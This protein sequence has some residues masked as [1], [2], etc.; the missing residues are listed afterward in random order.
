MNVLANSVLLQSLGYAIIHSLWQMALLWTAY[1]VITTTI[2]L[3]S[4]TKYIL[5][6]TIQIAGFLW[7][8][9]TCSFY[10]VQYINENEQANFPFSAAR[11]V[12]VVSYEANNFRSLLLNIMLQAEQLLPYLSVAYLLVLTML[13]IQWNKHYTTAQTLKNTGLHKINVQWKLFVKE[14]SAL[15]GIKKEVKI[16]LSEKVTTPLTIGFLKPIILVPLASINHLSVTQMEAVLLHELAHIKRMDYLLHL[17]LSVIE[18]VLFFNPFTKAINTHIQRERENSCDDW[19][20]QFQYNPTV[21][22]EA[23]L[24]VAVLNATSFPSFAMTAVKSKNSL[25]HRVRRMTEE[26]NILSFN[27]KK[28]LIALVF[29]LFAVISITWLLPKHNLFNN[30]QQKSLYTTDSSLNSKEDVYIYMKPMTAKISNPLFNPLFF[31]KNPLQEEINRN[32]VIT[33]QKTSAVKNTPLSKSVAETASIIQVTQADVFK[34]VEGVLLNNND[35]TQHT[36]ES[37]A[38]IDNIFWLQGKR[39][40]LDSSIHFWSNKLNQ[41]NQLLNNTFIALSK[42]APKNEIPQVFDKAI[43]FKEKSDSLQKIVKQNR[44]KVI[45]FQSTE[46]ADEENVLAFP[47]HYAMNFLRDT[48]NMNT[49]VSYESDVMIL[50]IKRKKSESD[51]QENSAQEETPKRYDIVI[52]NLGEPDK[53]LIIE[54]W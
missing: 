10:Y 4:K 33:E 26:K 34:V 54:I 17:F 50:T 38:K 28:H 30:T 23:L 8:V 9:L 18:I 45:Q 1:K 35:T 24:K 14:T 43:F 48:T 19:V 27:Y 41:Y 15:L 13:F 22:A 47:V 2:N 37:T 32:I 21:Y 52:S 39:F 51:C 12:V 11:N 3:S 46:A 7:F 53:R 6:T 49:S 29:I 42:E 44:K 16:F 20:L 31:F 40:S 25:L 36:T 5:A